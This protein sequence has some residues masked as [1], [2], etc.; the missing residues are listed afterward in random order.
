MGQ[1]GGGGE[2]GPGG[3]PGA[4]AKLEILRKVLFPLVCFL[5]GSVQKTAI[6]TTVRQTIVK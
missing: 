6:D 5:E 3:G 1:G 2:G 4:L